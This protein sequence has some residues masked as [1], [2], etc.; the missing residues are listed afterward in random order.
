MNVNTINFHYYDLACSEPVACGLFSIVF[1]ILAHLYSFFFT[2]EH[3]RR[4]PR[5]QDPRDLGIGTMSGVV[6]R[7]KAGLVG[8]GV[9]S[10]SY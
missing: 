6:G 7:K 3:E 8:F 9:G 5:T 10:R 2:A 4:T 1:S